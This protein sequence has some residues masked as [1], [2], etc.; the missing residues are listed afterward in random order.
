MHN[1][2]NVTIAYERTQENGSVG[3]VKENYL[4]DALS[5]TEAEERINKEMKPYINGDLLIDKVTRARIGELFQNKNGDRW[6]RCKVAFIALDESSGVEKRTSATMLAQAD[7]LKD[8]VEVIEKGMKET[9]ADYVIVS[10][11]GTNIMDIFPYSA[12]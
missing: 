10:V 11:A 4:V 8:A 3:K 6:Y 2:F 12:E 9:M 7:T 5:F 1:W